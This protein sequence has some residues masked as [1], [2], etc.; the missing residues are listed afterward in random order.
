M[1]VIGDSAQTTHN[2]CSAFVRFGQ[3]NGAFLRGEAPFSLRWDTAPSRQDS[4]RGL[5]E[6]RYPQ[7]RILHDAAASI[8]PAAAP[9]A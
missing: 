8:T 3:Q 4:I 1:R 6:Q 7:R 2:P 9:T 5:S